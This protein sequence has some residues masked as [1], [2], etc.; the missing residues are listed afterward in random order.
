MIT[1]HRF[2]AGLLAICIA[3]AIAGPSA[4]AQAPDY[5]I[6]SLGFVGEANSGAEAISPDGQTVAGFTDSDGF[7]WGLGQGGTI[8]PDEASRAFSAPRGVNDNG[9][10]VGIGATTF[11]GSGALPVVWQGGVASVLP[12]PAGQTLGRANAVN[13]AG[14]AVGSVDG[15]VLERAATFA[16]GG[17]GTVLTQTLAGGELRTAYG[18]NDAGRIVGSAVDPQNAAVT[19]GFYLDPGDAAA[20]DIGALT[21]L[22][23]NSA[24]AFAVSS[25]GLI[26][27]S[28]S[29]NSG[30]GGRA[31]LWSETGGMTEVPLPPATTTAGARGVNASGW[32]VGTAS[33]VTAVP[34][35]Y[36][37]TASYRLHDLIAAGGDGWD[38][39]SGTSN[40]AFAI[41]DNGT[42]V[43]RGLLDGNLTAFAMILVVTD[44]DGD[45]VADAS[46]NCTLVANPAQRD[47]DGDGFGNFCDGDYNNDGI[48]NAV[49]LGILRAGF[50]GSDPDLD[51]NGDGVVNAADLGWLRVGFFQPPGPAG[52]L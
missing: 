33:S 50:F 14:L 13:N 29:L 32:V 5:E 30:A 41:A 24:I 31:F 8:L 36:D 46:D 51:M 7:R 34:Y 20:T 43:G 44:S 39:I 22:G 17:S 18:V 9:V 10:V 4:F 16:V 3:A 42:I 38:L 6:V 48:V 40:G 12:L 21:A 35:L 28:S 23:H 19:K 15:G 1:T 26:A 52:S 47:T 27:G 37:G 49:D 25:N 2:S 45:G 11:F